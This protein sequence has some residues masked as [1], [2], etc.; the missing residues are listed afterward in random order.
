M[1]DKGL[2]VSDLSEVIQYNNKT[3]S[4]SSIDC[5]SGGV[6]STECSIEAGTIGGGG[7]CSVKCKNGYY[8]C[9][10]DQ[11]NK[12][13]CIKEATAPSSPPLGSKPAKIVSH[14]S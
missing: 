12:C 8:A 4:T 10:D 7:A 13:K 11:L 5:F 3:Y 6:R 14:H 2:P 9:C 1:V